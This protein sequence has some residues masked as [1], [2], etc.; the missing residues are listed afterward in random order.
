MRLRLPSLKRSAISVTAVAVIAL[1]TL[2]IAA[3]LGITLEPS[4]TGGQTTT[5]P[6]GNI[7]LYGNRD[8]LAI[9]VQ[10]SGF[11]AGQASA[12]ET[13]AK[14][15]VEAALIDVAQHPAWAGWPI[16]SEG[17]SPVVD[18]GCTAGPALYGE[19]TVP[20]DPRS[21]PNTFGREVIEVS[22]YRVFLF[23][24]PAD[25]IRQLTD[26]SLRARVRLSAEERV[27]DPHYCT[28]ATTGLYL[29]PEDLANPEFLLDALEKAIG[30]E[31][32]Y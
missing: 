27:C 16:L 24:L 20:D 31:A 18:I 9:C 30:L 29:A 14:L 11:E 26:G 17:L 22:Y 32:P 8:R 1:V 23:L 7:L 19:R 5:E 21:P 3:L 13:Q 15:S 25:E 28:F 4:L 12:V 6:A 10:A 2:G